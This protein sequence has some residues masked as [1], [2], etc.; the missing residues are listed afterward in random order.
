MFFCVKQSSWRSWYVSS[1]LSCFLLLK[2]P[3]KFNGL[4]QRLRFLEA[5]ELVSSNFN[6]ANQLLAKLSGNIQRI[7][8]FEYPLN[9]CQLTG[10]LVNIASCKPWPCFHSEFGWSACWVPFGIYME[11]AMDG[12]QLLI[13]SSVDVLASYSLQVYTLKFFQIS[14]NCVCACARACTQAQ[15]AF[16][17]KDHNLFDKCKESIITYLWWP[18]CRVN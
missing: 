9:E 15:I 7:L 16:K 11:N 17:I 14:F 18:N 10:M 12:K 8:G 2:R 4:L 3:E 13:K 5:H 6:S 1:L